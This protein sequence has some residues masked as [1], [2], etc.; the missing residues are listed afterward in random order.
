MPLRDCAVTLETSMLVRDRRRTTS[1]Q[2][3]YKHRK[4]PARLPPGL[5]YRCC[6]AARVAALTVTRSHGDRLARSHHILALNDRRC[7]TCKTDQPAVSLSSL[8]ADGRRLAAKS[9]PRRTCFSGINL[10]AT[11]AIRSNRHVMRRIRHESVCLEVKMIEGWVMVGIGLV[12]LLIGLGML[13]A[14]RWIHPTN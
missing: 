7:S 6:G 1:L 5:R 11:C 12:A 14:D 2:G 13:L 4:P 3:N 10:N 8:Q 9:Q